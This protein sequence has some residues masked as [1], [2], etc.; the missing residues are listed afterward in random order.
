MTEN[1]A[2]GRIGPVEENPRPEDDLMNTNSWLLVG[3]GVTVG[4]VCGL[5]MTPT[6]I[7]AAA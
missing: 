7:R 6:A 1:F 3:C 5:T 2:L 4:L